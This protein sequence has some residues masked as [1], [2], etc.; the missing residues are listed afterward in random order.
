MKKVGR[1]T[2]AVDT[3][4][5]RWSTQELGLGAAAMP[6]GTATATESA[7]ASRVSSIEAGNRVS[8]S[9]TTG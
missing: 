6:S 5:Q 4:R 1:L 8:N 9:C 2:P 3:S 7:S